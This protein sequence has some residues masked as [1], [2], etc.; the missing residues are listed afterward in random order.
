M[1]FATL[2][3]ATLITLQSNCFA[4][5]NSTQLVSET[6]INSDQPPGF[7]SRW[8]IEGDIQA[9]S[10]AGPA[11]PWLGLAGAYRIF[12]PVT[13]GLRGYLPLSHS[14][15]TSTYALQIYSRLRVVHGVNTDFFCEPSLSEDF[16]GL[17]P[18]NSYG[19]AIGA[20]TRV[21]PGLSVGMS[22]GLEVARVVVDSSGIENE[23]GFVVYPKIGLLANFNF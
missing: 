1:K 6:K 8:S 13:L 4:F 19:L 12:D 22:G 15:D 7:T 2:L 3:L 11:S 10:V 23:N 17:L 5:A 18:F 9:Q 21:A 20:L 14:V 16:Y